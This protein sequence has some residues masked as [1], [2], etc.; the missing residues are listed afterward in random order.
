MHHQLRLHDVSCWNFF[1]GMTLLIIFLHGGFLL[2]HRAKEKKDQHIVT[3]MV[4]KLME[5]MAF[6]DR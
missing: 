3:G 2:S 5:T 6:M 4:P 1:V